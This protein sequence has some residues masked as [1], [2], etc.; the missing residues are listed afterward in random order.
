MKNLHIENSY[1]IWNTS[2]MKSIIDKKCY[3]EYESYLT[4]AKLNRAYYSM[5]VEW[6]LHNIGYYI[7]KP[8]CAI[9]QIKK[10]NLRFKDVDINE[11]T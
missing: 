4:S 7:T 8:F 11:W 5:Y 2:E 3:E 6:W 10:I 1:N 9:D